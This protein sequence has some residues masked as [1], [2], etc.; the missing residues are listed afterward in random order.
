MVGVVQR[1]IDRNLLMN[2]SSQCMILD[3][4]LLQGGSKDDF[5]CS[6]TVWFS[7]R[8]DKEPDRNQYKN[9][10]RGMLF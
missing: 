3:K 9:I 4:Y 8:I 7:P 10:G 2:V 6:D 1:K 5:N